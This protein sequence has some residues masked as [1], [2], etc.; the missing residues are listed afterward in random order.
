VL[1]AHFPPRG[2]VLGKAE[3]ELV[4]KSVPQL[5]KW[6][7]QEWLAMQHRPHPRLCIAMACSSRPHEASLR[8]KQ[9]DLGP[10]HMNWPSDLF[11]RCSYPPKLPRQEVAALVP[12]SIPR[13]TRSLRFPNDSSG[14]RPEMSDLTPITIDSSVALT[15]AHTGKLWAMLRRGCCPPEPPPPPQVP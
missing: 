4:R 12:V 8:V 13:L 15:A 6:L 5:E 11:S 2:L 14:R 3:A 10:A 7:V 9:A 1:L